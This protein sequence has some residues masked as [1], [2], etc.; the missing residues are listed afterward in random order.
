MTCPFLAA[1]PFV[2]VARAIRFISMPINYLLGSISGGTSKASGSAG[3]SSGGNEQQKP[4]NPTTNGLINKLRELSC[5]ERQRLLDNADAAFNEWGE[6][7]SEVTQAIFGGK[8]GTPISVG[9][10][11]ERKQ[12]KVFDTFVWNSGTA[13][14]EYFKRTD[15]AETIKGSGLAAIFISH[16]DRVNESNLPS[17]I[18]SI[19][20]ASKVPTVL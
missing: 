11:I 7:I 6:A 14:T 19:T 10:G 3:T 4:E 1:P 8:E 5:D 17:N 18:A 9:P 20:H 13:L 12:V 15:V 2:V 16:S